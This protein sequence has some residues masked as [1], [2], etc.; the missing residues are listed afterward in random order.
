MK[1]HIH[2]HPPLLKKKRTPALLE[3]HF[4]LTFFIFFGFLYVSMGSDVSRKWPSSSNTHTFAICSGSRFFFSFFFFFYNHT[5]LFGTTPE[6]S[7]HGVK[8]PALC[9]CV[10][11]QHYKYGGRRENE[12]VKRMHCRSLSFPFLFSI[13]LFFFTRPICLSLLVCVSPLT[14]AFLLSVLQTPT[15]FCLSAPLPPT[16]PHHTIIMVL[17]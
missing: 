9:V 3:V 6:A 14:P 15:Y 8:C 5:F 13:C 16:P 7:L 2:F 17:L 12:H 10:G 11:V 1:R 4:V